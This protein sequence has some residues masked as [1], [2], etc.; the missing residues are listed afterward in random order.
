MLATLR[1]P[2][3]WLAWTWL[4]VS[5]Q[6][7]A[8]AQDVQAGS[9]LFVTLNDGLSTY[10]F[11]DVPADTFGTGSDFIAELVVPF[12]GV[13]LG[14]PGSNG[15]DTIVE[16]LQDAVLH[17]CPST[18]T[19]DV[20]IKALS[21][22][23]TGAPF[24]ITF[25]S[26]TASSTYRAQAC[27]SSVQAQPLG[28]MT[29]TRDRLKGGSFASTLP[30]T[31]RVVFTRVSGTMGDPE[32]ILDPAGTIFLDVGTDPGTAGKWSYT[33]TSSNGQCFNIA[34]SPG[35]MVDHDCNDVTPDQSFAASSNF[36][37]GLEWVV[38]SF[39]SPAC[40]FGP[41]CAGAS[42]SS[43]TLSMASAAM[44]G[45]SFDL[46]VKGKP[47]CP[48][49]IFLG[50]TALNMSF[51]L[52]VFGLPIGCGMHIGPLDFNLTLGPFLTDATGTLNATL[53]APPQ[54][55]GQTVFAQAFVL[56]PSAPGVLP[57][58]F[59]AV[60]NAIEVYFYDLLPAGVPATDTCTAP[61]TPV[62]TPVVHKFLGHTHSTSV[63][64]SAAPA[65]DGLTKTGI[66]GEP[67]IGTM[68]ITEF[69]A[70]PT[71]AS[72][73]ALGDW[74]EI[75]NATSV[76]HDVEG[77]TLEDDDGEVALI[78]SGVGTLIIPPGE[79]F[80][81]TQAIS[82]FL[83]GGVTTIAFPITGFTLD[84]DAD[85]IELRDT[86]GKLQHRVAYDTA[87]G[88]PVCSGAS[89][90]FTPNAPQ[91]VSA[92]EDPVNWCCTAA[93]FCSLFLPPD[94]ACPISMGAG[95]PSTPNAPNVCP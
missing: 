62:Y 69:M 81:L 38:G 17:G 36:F 42:G 30:V 5:V 41:N 27:L 85:E 16:R 74:I 59:G 19:V 75:F 70:D 14:N 87:T 61:C 34:T 15:A 46:V 77:W 56:D 22:Q 11:K 73:P 95:D 7:A 26:G 68:L 40:T 35:G 23:S 43:P 83:T 47:N 12:R 58:V 57:F 78:S 80:V 50:T 1:R 9:D 8:S 10:Q 94:P 76:P 33:N 28:S 64:V 63:D 93:L 37:P 32:V 67:Q 60:T 25:N 88:W 84:K 72:N 53:S 55:E 24:S 86:D 89:V 39:S 82:P 3:N 48:A 54:F 21:L 79:R 13:P 18:D 49:V 2:W 4:A 65:A 52:S 20:Q 66:P 92:A 6:G 90:C 29:I 71:A 51:D 44:S 31:L 45:A 91:F